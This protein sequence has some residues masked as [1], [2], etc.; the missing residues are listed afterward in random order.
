MSV[1][2]LLYRL[3]DLGVISE[4]YSQECWRYIGSMGW[5]KEEPHQTPP[6]EPRWLAQS[7]LRAFSEGLITQAGAEALLD[8]PLERS[9]APS[10]R[11]AFAALPREKRAAAL[12]KQA[13]AA[14]DFYTSEATDGADDEL[15][16]Y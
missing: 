2:A 16:E 15:V 14:A 6:E 5:R 4:R 11:R 9:D 13:A 1:A 7:A 3:R 12:A 10:R 8:R